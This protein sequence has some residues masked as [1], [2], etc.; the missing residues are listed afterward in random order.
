[1]PS[2]KIRELVDE[3]HQEIASK[4]NLSGEDLAELKA[5]AVDIQD[6]VSESDDLG[7]NSL[8]D[9]LRD[10]TERFE[11]THPRIR[12]RSRESVSVARRRTQLSTTGRPSRDRS[13]TVA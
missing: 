9:D 11:A 8:I 1:M 3:L 7:G 5:L 12:R 2:K 10:V 6:A 13:S 4:S